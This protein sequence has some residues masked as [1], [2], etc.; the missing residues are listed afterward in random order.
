M[1]KKNVVVKEEL[2]VKKVDKKPFE[3]AVDKKA[4][5]KLVVD[6]ADA[7]KH[8]IDKKYNKKPIKKVVKDEDADP[9]VKKN[10]GLKKAL[11][12]IIFFGVV[13]IG[14]LLYLKTNIEV[15]NPT[16]IATLS[17]SILFNVIILFV[18]FGSG[19]GQ[20]IVGRLKRRILFGTGRFVNTLY[21]SKNG[22]I[23]EEF[24]KVD[25][26]TGSFK[27]LDNT[28]TRNPSLLHHFKKIPTY[29]H[30]EGSPDPVNIFDD[31]LA[32]DISNREIDI[33]MSS[34]GAFDFKLWL[35]KNTLYIFIGIVVIVGAAVVSAY[36]G[37]NSMQMLRDGTYHA[38]K[39]IPE[40]VEIVASTVL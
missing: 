26:E 14:F 19:M 28:Y 25:K 3:K 4:D 24:K 31:K 5:K 34:K 7:I 16:M 38:V 12:I 9:L 11:A 29:F 2:V 1:K 8:I 30:R 33:V 15:S 17:F 10:M 13:S 35:Q 23:K 39:C 32:G 20:D 40:V 18:L 22:P 37:F 6:E 27:I 36:L 21:I